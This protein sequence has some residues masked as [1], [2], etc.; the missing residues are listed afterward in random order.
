MY[1]VDAKPNAEIKDCD[2]DSGFLVGT[3]VSDYTIS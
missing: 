2:G 1:F 3:H